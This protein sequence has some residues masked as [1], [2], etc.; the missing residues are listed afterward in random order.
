MLCLN[1]LAYLLKQLKLCV[2]SLLHSMLQGLHSTHILWK[3][4]S[5]EFIVY[6]ISCRTL[7]SKT[8]IQCQH[9]YIVAYFPKYQQENI[10]N[11]LKYFEF[12]ASLT[13][14]SEN[15]KFQSLLL[16]LCPYK[17]INMK[18]I[19]FLI[20]GIFDL[21]LNLQFSTVMIYLRTKRSHFSLI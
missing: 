1:F 21:S 7:Q 9:I 3:C 12:S 20:R 10:Y 18:I 13:L 14:K 16:L 6:Q 11:I 5:L 17:Q 4:K 19:K 8:F 15:F 2:V